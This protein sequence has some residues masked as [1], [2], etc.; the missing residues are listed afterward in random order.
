MSNSKEY[1]IYYWFYEKPVLL[2]GIFD[3]DNVR[4]DLVNLDDNIILIN[5]LMILIFLALV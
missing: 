1:R 2:S 3:K 5:V 4:L